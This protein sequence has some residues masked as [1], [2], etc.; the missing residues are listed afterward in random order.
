M[1]NR[2]L[3]VQAMMDHVEEKRHEPHWQEVEENVVRYI[4]SGL[5][6]GNR[7]SPEEVNHVVGVLEVNA[8]EVETDEGHLARGL[9]PLTALMSHECLSNTR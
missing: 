8:F 6:L 1:N 4:C 7:F 2:L 3:L 5:A 9:Y